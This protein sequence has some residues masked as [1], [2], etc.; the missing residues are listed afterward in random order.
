[1]A[2]A[3]SSLL[4]ELIQQLGLLAQLSLFEQLSPIESSGHLAQLG[5]LES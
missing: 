5:L 2:V 4:D 1:M 3:Q